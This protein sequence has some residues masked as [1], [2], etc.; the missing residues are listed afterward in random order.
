MSN[1]EKGLDDQRLQELLDRYNLVDADARHIDDIHAVAREAYRLG[2]TDKETEPERVQAQLDELLRDDE[3]REAALA[4]LNP[5]ERR[6]AELRF[7]LVDE[8][9]GRSPDLAAVGKKLGV[10]RE[11]VRQL[12]HSAIKKMLSN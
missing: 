8:G 7:G 4:R 1:G 12:E 10:S 9:I 6:T 11:R 2:W 3:R 5:Q